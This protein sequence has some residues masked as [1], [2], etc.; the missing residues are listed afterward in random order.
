M[1]LTQAQLP[2][3]DAAVLG[4]AAFVV[5]NAQSLWSVAKHFHVMAHEGMHATTGSLVGIPIRGIILK[6]NGEGETQF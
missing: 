6:R 4:V 1:S 3:P 2:G 5:V